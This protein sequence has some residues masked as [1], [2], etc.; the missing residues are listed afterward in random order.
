MLASH[1]ESRHRRGNRVSG[2]C[3]TWQKP[4]QARIFSA[5]RMGDSKGARPLVRGLQ[6][7]RAPSA[8]CRCAAE[9]QQKQSILIY[10]IPAA[11]KNKN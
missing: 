11:L 9:A 5:A 3:V 8:L 6:R 1:G 2:F 7:V 10:L 4:S